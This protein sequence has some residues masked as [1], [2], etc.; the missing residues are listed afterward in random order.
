MT[1]R[2]VQTPLGVSGAQVGG[3]GLRHEEDVRGRCVGTKALREGR[4]RG[5]QGRS[6][7]SGPSRTGEQLLGF[8]GLGVI[9][10][11]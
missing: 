7:T 10:L 9:V 5:T 4:D 6:I 3:T 8:F 11:F 1:P 2:R